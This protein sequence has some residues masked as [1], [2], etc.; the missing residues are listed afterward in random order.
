MVRTAGSKLP[1]ADRSSGFFTH[2]TTTFVIT[3]DVQI[4][5]NAIGLVQTINI[6]NIAGIESAEQLNAT[7]G[8]DVGVD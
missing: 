6:L 7:L 4:V 8:L 5:P 3:D 2:E 1:L